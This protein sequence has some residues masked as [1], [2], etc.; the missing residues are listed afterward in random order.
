MDQAT[1][2]NAA[3]V[4][5]MAAAAGSLRSQAQEL[6]QNV[7]V[8][9]AGE[10]GASGYRPAPFA[11]APRRAA[12]PKPMASPAPRPKLRS[13]PQAKAPTP[14]AKAPQLSHQAPAKKPAAPSPAP[15]P[16][17]QAKGGDDDWETF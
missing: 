13:A 5:Q 4:E 12:P 16:V 6:V 3:L 7:A 2:Q 15:A 8:F 11:S 14:K 17:A 1:Q 9:Q 10:Q